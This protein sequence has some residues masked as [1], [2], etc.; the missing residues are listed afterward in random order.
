MLTCMVGSLPVLYLTTLSEM[1][2][3]C[4]RIQEHGLK[5]DTR[6]IMYCILLTPTS[7]Q[8]LYEFTNHSSRI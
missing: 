1:D 8:F 6:S 2:L 5:N 3:Q 7:R 4:E